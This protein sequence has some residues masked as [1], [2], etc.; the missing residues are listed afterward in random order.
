MMNILKGVI[1]KKSVL[2]AAAGA[3]ALSAAG[4]FAADLPSRKAAPVY[5]PPP[6]PPPLWTGFYGGLNIGGGWSA[7]SSNNS[8]LPYSDPGYG[9]GAVVAGTPNLFFFPG[10]GQTNSNTGGVIGGGQ[11]GYNYQFG[12]FL[13]GVEADIQGTSITGGN[14]GNFAGVYNSPFSGL[15]GSAGVVTPLV[16]GNGG[17]IGLPWFGTVRGRVGYLVTPTL[18][19]YG[20]GGFAYGGVQVFNQTNTRT[21][22][23]AGGG[24]EWM[25]LPNWS[26]K[27]EYL[28]TDLSSGGV[29]GGWGWNYG[30]NRHPQFN[31]VRLGVNYHFNVG[32]PAPVLAKY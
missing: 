26:A 11:V 1:M 20:T 21:G 27:V 32:A 19:L 22:W 12:Q 29:Q 31:T 30:N 6:P 17:N 23:T 10:G 5:V 14:Q 7:N 9:V 18:L 25:F 2:L 15:R 16:T 3:L 4:A 13:A 24:A 28:Y 8:Y